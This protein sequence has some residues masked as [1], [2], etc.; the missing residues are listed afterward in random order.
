MR[1]ILGC[2]RTNLGDSYI[3]EM[4]LRHSSDFQD[5]GKLKDLDVWF[6]AKRSSHVAAEFQSAPKS[7]LGVFHHEIQELKKKAYA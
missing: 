3:V 6:V 7:S 4:V 1:L 5:E 2:E